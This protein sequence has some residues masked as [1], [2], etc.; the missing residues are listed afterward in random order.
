MIGMNDLELGIDRAKKSSNQAKED[1]NAGRYMTYPTYVDEYNDIV[2]WVRERYKD[3]RLGFIQTA[4]QLIPS[5]APKH[6]SDAVVKLDVLVGYLEEKLETQKGST[7]HQRKPSDLLGSEKKRVFIVMA[8]D[9][10]D[11]ELEGINHTIKQTCALF[12]LTT[13]RSDE[14][15]HSGS[16]TNKVKER[17]RTAGTIIADLSYDKPNVYYELG[18]AHGLGREQDVILL[19]SKDLSALPFDVRDL[20]VIYYEGVKDLHEELEKRL[21]TIFEKKQ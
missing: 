21:S 12:G 20:K 3:S 1:L 19:S 6:L 4:S 5:L 8:I 16:I 2:K 11:K 7:A 10:T 18:Y 17:I 9:K 13:E 14:I 15:Q